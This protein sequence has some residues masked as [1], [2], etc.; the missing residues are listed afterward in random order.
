MKTKMS[1]PKTSHYRDHDA[2]FNDDWRGKATWRRAR[3]PWLA[4][5]GR[6]HVRP[7]REK[8]GCRCAAS[9]GARAPAIG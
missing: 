3:V 8:R 6:N 4:A 2:R 1:V 9:H 7:G 5:A